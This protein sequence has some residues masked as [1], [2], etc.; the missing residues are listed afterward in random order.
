MG[1]AK[2]IGRI[3]ALA[4]AL[5]IGNVRRSATRAASVGVTVLAVTAAVVLEPSSESPAVKLSADST[6][7]IVCGTSCPTPD[8]YWIDSVK[9]NFIAPTHPDQDID[10]VAVTTP[11][12]YWPITGLARLIGFAVG[13]PNIGGFAGAMWPD[14]PWWKLSG[15]FDLTVD[16]SIRAGAANLEAAMAEHGDDH[17]VINGYSQGATVVNTVK[18][19]LAEQYPAGTDAPDIDFVLGGDPN[20]PN[21]GLSARFPGLYVP[22][23]DLTF[24]GPAPTDTQFDTV[25]ISRQYDMAS[26]FPLYPLNVIATANALLGFVYLHTNPFDVSLP[27]DPTTSP[28]YQ[29]TH[30]DT[31]YYF[32]ETENL[33]LFAPLRML[34]VPEALIDAVEPFFRVLVELGYDRDIP[35]WE[36]TPARLI[37]ELDPAKVATDLANAVGEGIANTLAIV[38]LSPP[39]SGPAP[40]STAAS[41][42]EADQAEVAQT[43]ISQQVT[44]TDV[45][46]TEQVTSTDRAEG[47]DG[48]PMEAAT[49]AD[50]PT[51]TEQL[52]STEP[53]TGTG[54]ASTTTAPP[55]TSGVAGTAEEV[56]T[57]QTA[58]S[59]PPASAVDSTSVR[60]RG[61]SHLGNGP[62]TPT[63]GTTAADSAT[64]ESSS[65]AQARSSSADSNS[66]ASDSSGG[67]AD[68]SN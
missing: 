67:D 43:D 30:G 13:D 14:E 48:M 49:R 47:S 58:A 28:A 62:A 46:Q 22:I 59:V 53:Q 37:P 51:Q 3:G 4:A 56:S 64:T 33:P 63:T 35:L 65:S 50:G 20:L 45:S 7:L 38:G 40:V 52:G 36:P 41:P 10:Y 1:S 26:D 17:L 34:G 25:E 5:G 8:A 61:V 15:L 57:G 23:L 68:G 21:G 66:S 29:G 54:Q 2:Y 32:F 16:Q 60:P 44:A 18:R 24:D 19:K 55:S 12:E 42:T 31:S 11:Q 9:N 39:P 27:E 6:A